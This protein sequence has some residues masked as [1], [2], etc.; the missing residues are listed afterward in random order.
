MVLTPSNVTKQIYILYI[1][2]LLLT[3]QINNNNPLIKNLRL[4]PIFIYFEN[5]RFWS[6]I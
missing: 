2:S 5:N 4:L 1:Q 3:D 6:N